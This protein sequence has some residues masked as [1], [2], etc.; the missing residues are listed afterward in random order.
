VI[1]LHCH[2]LPGV[3]DGSESMSDSLDMARALAGLGFRAVCCTP[4][5]QYA[6][7]SRSVEELESLRAE[8]QTA[9]T[10]EGISLE[11][12]P[13]GEHHASEVLEVLAADRLLRYRRSD[14][15]LLEFSL[16]G[17]PP[18]VDEMLFR[19]QLKGLTTVLAHVERYPEVQA[20]PRALVPLRERGVQCLVNLSSLAKRWDAA[21]QASARALLQIGLVDAVS[22]DLHDP[23]GVAAVA[24]G[25][26]VLRGLVDAGT[27]DRLTRTTPAALAG[28]EAGRTA[29][30]A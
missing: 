4:H 24:E 30:G 1:D 2:L 12:L 6:M 3:D 14:A 27:F 22:S 25:L 19:F 9:V 21:S 18:R 10:R 13:G 17:F 16:R 7:F 5:V 26:A 20:D 29:T 15:F 28:L 11:L 8:L 23:D